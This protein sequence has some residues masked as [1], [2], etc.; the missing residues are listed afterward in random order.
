MQFKRVAYNRNVFL[1]HWKR[2][3]LAR[4]AEILIIKVSIGIPRWSV[5]RLA[6]ITEPAPWTRIKILNCYDV[7]IATVR[8]DRSLF[9]HWARV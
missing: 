3:E 8:S 2:V 9:P 7:K 6:V 1:R 5:L 4:Y